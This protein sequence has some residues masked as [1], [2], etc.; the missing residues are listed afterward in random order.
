V[1][2]L[3]LTKV[4]VGCVDLDALVERLA[5]RAGSAAE[6]WV[7]TRY[8]PT[9]HAELIGGS[10]YW[11][12]KHRLVARSPILRFDA[13]EN[14]RCLIRIEARLVPVVAR[15]KR[16][17][18]GWRYLTGRQAPADLG[19]DEADALAALPPQLLGKLAALGLV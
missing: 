11:I 4:A 13:D 19:G 1:H 16:A 15:P 6:S 3:H 10:L 7:D 14:G 8:R 2:P 12:V 5:G 9:R 18:Q 17:H